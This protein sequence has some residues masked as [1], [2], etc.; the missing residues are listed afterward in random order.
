MILGLLS[1]AQ[2]IRGLALFQIT[3]RF[4]RGLCLSHFA[5]EFVFKALQQDGLSKSNSRV[6]SLNFSS[7]IFI[8]FT[9]IIAVKALL[10]LF[11]GQLH[12]ILVPSYKT[13]INPQ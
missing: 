7:Q 6:S 4:G 9:Y 8:E 13:I 3:T 5:L 10:H 11:L 12:T 1:L 2:G